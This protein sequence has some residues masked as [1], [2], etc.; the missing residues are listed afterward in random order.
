MFFARDREFSN[1]FLFPCRSDYSTKAL[2]H[3][4]RIW[5][6]R[7]LADVGVSRE[8][9]A[10]RQDSIMRRRLRIFYS[11]TVQ[12]VG[13]R[14]QVQRVAAGYEVTG[15]VRNLPEG[16][17]EVVAEGEEAELSAFGVAIR[18]SGVGSLIRNETELWSD[19]SGE[20]RGFGITQ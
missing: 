4:A 18:E 5:L 14:Y 10:E 17:V 3:L 6:S 11:G 9:S 2:P 20:F 13:F 7:P 12:G 16:R 1:S 8:S 15:F 19:A